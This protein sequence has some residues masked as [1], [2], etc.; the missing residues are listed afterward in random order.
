[1]VATSLAEMASSASFSK[2]L[3]TNTAV[4]PGPAT[5][6]RSLTVVFRPVAPTTVAPPAEEE[7]AVTSEPDPSTV[8]L[9]LRKSGAASS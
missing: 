9:S 5:I 3:W 1:M 7:I 4:P 6:A 8:T 2:P